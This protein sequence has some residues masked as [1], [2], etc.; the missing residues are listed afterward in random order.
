MGL[1]LALGLELELGLGLGRGSPG[2]RELA[3]DQ[4]PLGT[5]LA[6]PLT[7]GNLVEGVAETVGVERGAATLIRVRVRVRV[8]LIL[9]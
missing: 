5:S 9:S 4:L 1:G 3:A 2:V 6:E 8:R 7:L